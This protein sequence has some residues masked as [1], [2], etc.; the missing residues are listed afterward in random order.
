MPPTP[1]EREGRRKKGKGEEKRAG[2]GTTC[3][4]RGRRAQRP[5]PVAAPAPQRTLPGRARAH[6]PQTPTS[7]PNSPW[8]PPGGGAEP[9]PAPRDGVERS[10]GAAE[11][12]A[13]GRPRPTLLALL[14][15]APA[16]SAP[17]S[18]A[19]RPAG[20]APGPSGSPGISHFPSGRWPTLL[21][22]PGGP[23]RER[24]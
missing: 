17:Q 22:R 18:G 3:G 10:A 19:L 14:T 4:S 8:Q 21:G 13:P 20:N 2:P 6:S 1:G 12:E 16:H 15:C 24:L 5:Q 9:S 23:Q 7:P 11:A